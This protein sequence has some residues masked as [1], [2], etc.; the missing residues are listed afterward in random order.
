MRLFGVAAN[1]QGVRMKAWTIE[2]IKK[3]I[4]DDLGSIKRDIEE[5]QAQRAAEKKDKGPSLSELKALEADAFQ[6]DQIDAN[7]T[8]LTEEQK[9]QVEE[10]IAW[11]GG[12]TEG[13]K[14][15]RRKK[16]CSASRPRATLSTST[17]TS[18]GLSTMSTTSSAK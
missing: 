7:L 13:G 12:R 4:G 3:A 1:K 18:S 11:S 2:A 6:A 9:A 5:V 8:S 15:R 17:T 16:P 10:N 14:T